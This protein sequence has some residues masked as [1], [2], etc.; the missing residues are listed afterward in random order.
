M[1]NHNHCANSHVR[2]TR[3]LANRSPLVVLL[4]S[5]LPWVDYGADGSGTD[6]QNR[7]HPDNEHP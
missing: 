3:D 4:E 5:I 1:D 6:Q 2:V 7:H